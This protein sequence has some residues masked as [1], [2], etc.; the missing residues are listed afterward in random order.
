MS[1]S[2]NNKSINNKQINK[3]KNKTLEEKLQIIKE[4]II[5]IEI[6]EDIISKLLNYQIPHLQNLIFSIQRNNVVLDSSDTGTG[7]TYTA[8]ALCKQLNLKP[9]VVC[10]KSVVYNWHNICN[11]FDIVPLGIVNYE[12]LKRNKYYH[13]MENFTEDIRETCPYINIIKA[14]KL[15]I[16]TNLPIRDKNGNIKKI[17]QRIDW[18]LPNNT[19]IIYDEAH[20]GKNA[21]CAPKPS[22]NAK[23]IVSI[24][25]VLDQVK[26]NPNKKIYCLILSAT[27]TDKPDRFDVILHLFDLYRP[28]VKK[29]YKQYLKSLGDNNDIIM[30]KIHTILYPLRASRMKI[31]DIPSGTFMK[32]DVQAVIYPVSQEIANSVEEQHR[33]IHEAMNSLREKGDS[34]G[35]G[36][37]IRAQNKIEVLKTGVIVN[38]CVQYL[39][40]NKSIVIFINFNNSKQVIVDKLLESGII[41]LDKIGFIDGNQTISERNDTVKKFQNDEL[42]VLLAHIKAGGVGISLHDIKGDRQ[43]VTLINSNWSAIDLK[44]ALGRIYRAGAKTD[45]IQRIV[46]C[47]SF[48]TSNLSRSNTLTMSIEEK[49][50]N[51]INEKLKNIEILNNSDLTC[52]L[53]I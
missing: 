16:T 19:L 52:A 50:A 2:K 25:T 17:I 46:Y 35:L 3:T 23:L 37:I 18:N 31:S 30:R 14:D 15:D 42:Y 1:L 12:T 34:D 47:K 51:N 27:P 11:I 22:I 9:L 26:V 10:P 41:N 53:K 13:D 39:Q 38:E 20:V 24:K 48:D 7:K 28:Y 6:N 29:S 45:S 49:I 36:A 33:I 43:R 21:L 40:E 5:S 32:N 4:K 8:I 44:Q